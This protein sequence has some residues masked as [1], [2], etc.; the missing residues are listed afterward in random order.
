MHTRIFEKKKFVVLIPEL[1]IRDVYPGSEFFQPG[2]RVKKIAD[3]GSA[4]KN[5]SIFNSK[6]AH[7]N[8]IRGVHA[9]S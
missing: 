3:P 4:S 5:L 1:R 6:Q 7:G 2:S 8:M 9:G